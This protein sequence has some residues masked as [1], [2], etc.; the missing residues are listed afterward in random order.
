MTEGD[1][2][3]AEPVLPEGAQCQSQREPWGAEKGQ[4]ILHAP[5]P[6][7]VRRGTWGVGRR[8]GQS[9]PWLELSSSSRV[10]PF[11]PRGT[12]GPLPLP[13]GAQGCLR[14]EQEN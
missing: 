13:V 10:P 3:G 4:T 7:L 1:R 11:L 12:L 14:P 9:G 6:H 2:E 5:K 8:D